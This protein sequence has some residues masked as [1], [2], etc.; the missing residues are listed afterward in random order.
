[1]PITR[2]GTGPNLRLTSA[3]TKSNGVRILTGSAAM[4]SSASRRLRTSE[5]D[6]EQFDAKTT[7]NPAREDQRPAQR[8]RGEAGAFPDSAVKIEG[9]TTKI[10]RAIERSNLS[11][12]AP[13]VW[14]PWQAASLDS[15]KS[16][17]ML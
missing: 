1:M 14:S 8:H 13:S 10:S 2:T 15:K 5:P 4:P 12:F 3:P 9:E 11:D 17:T 6:R 7:P 16:R